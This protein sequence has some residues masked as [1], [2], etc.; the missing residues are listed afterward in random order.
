M[1]AVLGQTLKASEHQKLNRLLPKKAHT[2]TGK[3][4]LAKC[5]EKRR[6]R[7]R[8]TTFAPGSETEKVEHAVTH[9]P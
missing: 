7:L 2:K 9:M 1:A 6:M 4:S 5:Y 8:H 3:S